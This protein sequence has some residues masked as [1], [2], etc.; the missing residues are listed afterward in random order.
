M[1][2]ITISSIGEVIEKSTLIQLNVST[3]RVYSEGV[4]AVSTK[5]LYTSGCS[6]FTCRIAGEGVEKREPSYTVG[7]NINWYNLYGKQYGSTS[8]NYI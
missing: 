4:L 1:K 3:V 5:H 2:I 7:G 6:N 8:E